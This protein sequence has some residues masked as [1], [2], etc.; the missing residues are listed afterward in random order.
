[1]KIVIM[2]FRK[3]SPENENKT[4]L[5]KYSWKQTKVRKKLAKMAEKEE[6]NTI[7]LN[8]LIGDERGSGAVSILR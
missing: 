8:I 4:G 1:M 7:D 2:Q 3:Q 5:W 6:Y